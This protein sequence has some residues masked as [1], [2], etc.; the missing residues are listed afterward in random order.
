MAGDQQPLEILDLVEQAGRLDGEMLLSHLRETRVDD[1]VLVAQRG[2]DLLDGHAELRHAVP[3]GLDVHRLPALAPELD[4]GDVLHQQQFAAQELRHLPQLGGRVLRAVH[5][6][7]DPPHVAEIV[8]HHGRTGA[9]RQLRL[10]VVHLSP[11]L[12]PHLRQR[13]LVV[14]VLDAH[15][16]RGQAP[17]GL[18]LDLLELTEPLHRPLD[19]VADLLLHLLGRGAGIGREDQRLLDGELGVLEPRQA[20]EG[21]G[22]PQQQHHGED[23]RGG[24]VA[25]RPGGGIH[26]RGSA[27]S[28]GSAAPAVLPGAGARPRWLPALPPRGRR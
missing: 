19:E 27:V 17:V 13:E 16:H 11:Q 10:D 3:V 9:G 6:N 15:R 22:T 2:D 26:R 21:D 24:A 14:L 4:L 8:V 1:Q 25:Q 18:G 12:V 7:E 5:G 20:V 28:P 23:Q